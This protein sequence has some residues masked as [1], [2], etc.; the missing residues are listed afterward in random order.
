MS[1]WTV[2]PKYLDKQG[3]ISLWR[4]GLLAQKVLNG[5]LDVKLSNPIWQEFRQGGG[6]VEK[7]WVGLN[8]G[9]CPQ[10]I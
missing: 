1:L 2:H 5:E 8:F 6:T 3:L 9:R 10:R 4:E 7:G